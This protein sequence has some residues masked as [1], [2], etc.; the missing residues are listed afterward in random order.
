VTVHYLGMTELGR[1]L[2]S[3]VSR[4]AVSKWRERHPASSAYPFPAPDA[5]IGLV[6]PDG[7]GQG[8]PGWLPGRLPEIEAWRAGLPG[9]TGRPKRVNVAGVSTEG[10]K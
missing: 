2:T 6:G 4:H 1:A 5:T 9:R 10:D 8:V 3:P 7:D